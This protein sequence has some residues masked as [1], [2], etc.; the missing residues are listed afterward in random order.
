[1]SGV[2][3]ITNS[4]PDL[5]SCVVRGAHL[6]NCDGWRRSYDAATGQTTHDYEMIWDADARENVRTLIEC[7]GCP[8]RQAEHGLLCGSHF[9]KA[10]DIVAYH[11][12]R[13]LLVDLVTHLWSIESSGVT[14]DNDRVT[15]AFGSK[16]P[17]SESRILASQIYMD[18]A[19]AAVGF[20]ND[21]KAPEPEWHPAGNM[22]EGL[23]TGASVE[24]V[25]FIV[26]R[27]VQF[28]DQNIEQ[29]IGKRR[30]AEGLVRAIAT[31]QSALRR[32]PLVETKPRLV[33]GVR[34]PVCLKIGM[35]W[36]PPIYF[37]DEVRVTCSRCGNSQ[38]HEWLDAYVQ[39]IKTDPRRR[40]T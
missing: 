17:I 38:T 30:G 26:E 19:S 18:L 11:E 23:N 33:P 35:L 36:Q 3:C 4:V 29:M 13:L 25:G 27:L 32:F 1:M 12:G 22:L 6:S 15:G 16:W 14:D 5:R 31:V 40:R 28:V 34:C 7:P 9:A 8:P 37:E 21:W 10:D 24:T 2:V 39:N 20:A